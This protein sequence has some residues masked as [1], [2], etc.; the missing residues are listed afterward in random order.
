MREIENWFVVPGGR[1]NR[2]HNPFAK[3]RKDQYGQVV[4]EIPVSLLPDTP[5]P[6]VQYMPYFYVAR[7]RFDRPHILDA[8]SRI[9]DRW[10]EIPAPGVKEIEVRVE[11]RD[12][13]MDYFTEW[14]DIFEEGETSA[15]S[16]WE[17]PLLKTL[18]PPTG[19]IPGVILRVRKPDV[20]HQ[21][22]RLQH[23]MNKNVP[24]PFAAE[25]WYGAT[26]PG[27]VVDYMPEVSI[28]H[29]LAQRKERLPQVFGPGH[30]LVSVLD[31]VL[32]G[33]AY[34]AA[35]IVIADESF[36]G[37]TP[38]VIGRKIARQVQIWC[39]PDKHRCNHE[40]G[41]CFL[42]AAEALRV[43]LEQ[44]EEVILLE[45]LGSTCRLNAKALL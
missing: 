35:F 12:D 14:C 2:W 8:F 19:A 38:A 15:S 24:I 39:H 36:P 37:K 30:P 25:L 10:F 16:R 18:W 26:P 34:D 9:A 42:Q 40:D 11:R 45:R 6:P 23:T 28:P 5:I 13:Y 44:V 29:T 32:L 3:D 7:D 41:R 17:E 31:T 43:C 4:D 27:T 22:F 21:S 20:R 1:K 33:N